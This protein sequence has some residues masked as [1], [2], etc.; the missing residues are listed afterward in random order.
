MNFVFLLNSIESAH[1]T[2]TAIVF[3]ESLVTYQLFYQRV[4]A[5]AHQI[6]TSNTPKKIIVAASY[7]LDCYAS[8]IAIWLTGNTYIPSRPGRIRATIQK[9]NPDIL[10]S[11]T[12]PKEDIRWVDNSN[13][14][15]EG[16]VNSTYNGDATAYILSTSGTTGTPKHIPVS[17]SNLS[18]FV[19]SFLSLGVE[20]KSSDSFL[21]MTEM[22]F[23]MSIISTLIPLCIG[24]SIHTID[25]EGIKSQ[26]ALK[27]LL[28]RN[29]TI[30]IAPPSSIK[31]LEPYLPELHLPFL[32]HTFFGAEALETNLVYKWL[33]S[34][35]NSGCTNLYGPSEGGI[36]ATSYTCGDSETGP[37]IPIGKNCKNI[38]SIIVDGELWISGE[39][40]FKGYSDN[41][42][43]EYAFELLEE[44]TWYKTGDLVELE[45]DGNYVFKG[46]KDRQIKIL[47][48]RVELKGIEEL[49]LKKLN[50]KTRT[51]VIQN[52]LG[53]IHYGLFTEQSNAI[54]KVEDILSDNEFPTPRWINEISDLIL[55]DKSPSEQNL[56]NLH[57]LYRESN[58]LILNNDYSI[59][60]S[61]SN[62]P[63]YVFNIQ[64]LSH[65]IATIVTAIK[66]GKA[67]NN[68]LITE[69]QLDVNEIEINNQELV[70]VS[71][72]PLLSCN[73]L[74]LN[75]NVGNSSALITEIAIEQLEEW[76]KLVEANFGKQDSSLFERLMKQSCK[77]FLATM[78]SKK[79]GAAMAYT[80]NGVTGIYHVSVLKSHQKLG[81][82]SG[83]IKA[84][85]AEAL[86]NGSVKTIMQSSNQG[87]STWE[88][89]GLNQKGNLYLLKLPIK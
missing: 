89:M 59:V 85:N 7:D 17:Y 70:P 25:M 79:V 84:C 49:L 48:K 56:A 78:G 37:F 65:S 13:C 88:N 43:S 9:H 20:L 77:L 52:N 15:Y 8:I 67:P 74:Q 53:I 55:L 44:Q 23:D 61:C 34:A 30:C 22:K 10:L 83:L 40:V 4:H 5:I 87:L 76:L 33:A 66:E 38:N 36:F 29:T 86:A 51:T 46:R 19:D 18:C 31:L 80:R 2:D 28:D 62:W 82:G 75:L 16:N 73:P 58:K 6:G 42:L 64:D 69:S 41:S 57:S 21:Q 12:S 3:P 71:I 60:T 26:E 14:E 1:Q 81:V 47:G 68:L 11:N 35:K 27:C 72:W 50:L 63:N 32:K 24:A 45:S 54:A 39:Q